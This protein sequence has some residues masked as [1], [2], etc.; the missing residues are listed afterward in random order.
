MSPVGL[1]SAAF[2]PR[3][4]ACRGLFVAALALAS[5]VAPAAAAADVVRIG[6]TGMALAA[7]REIGAAFTAAEP[8]TIV[9]VLP[10]LGTPGGL[11]ALQERAV[12]IA[13]TGRRL[14]DAERAK[15]LVEALCLRTPLAFVSAHPAPPGLR[16]ADL[17]RLYSE[18]APRWPDGKPLN[19][20]MRT[21]AGSEN[22]YLVAFQPTM[23]SALE[24]AY[25]R[26]GVPVATTDQENA[27]LAQRVEGSF[28]VMS[29]LQLRAEKLD[30]R[31][32][33]LDGVE[34]RAVT[35]EDRTYPLWVAVC[36]VVTGEPRPQTT[37]LLSYLRSP[38]G[39]GLLRTYGAIPVE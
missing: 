1:A 25:G 9:E 12:D 2:V 11:R 38:A 29:V 36:A 28:A 10:S 22:D 6:G 33:A 18:S 31:P 16:G 5:W 23:A 35:L 37:R 19:V 17:P 27:D 7:M 26:S 14:T 21:R 3:R 8:G 15:G 39:L 34:P 13:L 30:L 20:I 4:T 24:T 32:V